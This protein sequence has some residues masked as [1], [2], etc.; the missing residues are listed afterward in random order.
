MGYSS[1]FISVAEDCRSTTDEVL[2]ERAGRR[3]VA[4]TQYAVLTAADGRWTQEDVLFASS[5]QFRGHDV[6]EI[7]LGRLRE[8]Y[9]SQPR[10]FVRVSADQDVRLGA[11]F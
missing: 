5:P 7:N 2:P 11:A 9:F 6:D 3:T 8:E 10:A 1:T 4:V